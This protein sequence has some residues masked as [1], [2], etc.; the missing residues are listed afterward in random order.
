MR[1]GIGRHC[2]DRECLFGITLEELRNESGLRLAGSNT[3]LAGELHRSHVR[4]DRGLPISVGRRTD[5]IDEPAVARRQDNLC[6]RCVSAT[7][8]VQVELA[9]IDIDI[10]GKLNGIA[11]RRS[12][13][14][15]DGIES[16]RDLRSGLIVRLPGYD[17]RR[18]RIFRVQLEGQ[19]LRRTG[20]LSGTT[21][22]RCELCR[23]RR[24][25]CRLPIG[26]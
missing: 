11:E 10:A 22:D 2:T 18:A 13:C 17:N 4:G 12:R 9:G 5:T 21:V 8:N 7:D 23:D 16:R 14:A 26:A 3:G 20:K 6:D 24:N 1:R 25:G 15:G 19:V